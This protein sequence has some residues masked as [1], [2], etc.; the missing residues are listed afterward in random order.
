MRRVLKPFPWKSFQ[1]RSA[2]SLAA[3]VSRIKLVP[4]GHFCLAQPP[5]QVDLAILYPGPEVDQADPVVFEL[6][7]QARQF[8]DELLHAFLPALELGLYRRKLFTMQPS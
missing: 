6:N 4:I 5:A 2:E 8:L 7:T 1:R 3:L